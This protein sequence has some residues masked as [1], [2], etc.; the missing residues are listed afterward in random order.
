MAQV[1][2]WDKLI[3]WIGRREAEVDDLSVGDTARMLERAKQ[4]KTEV[5]ALIDALEAHQRKQVGAGAKLIA[6]TSEGEQVRV[7]TSAAKPDWVYESDDDV[8]ALVVARSLD[9]RR[10]DEET[11]EALES[12]AAAVARGISTVWKLAADKAR[13]GGDGKPGLAS[14]GIPIEKIRWRRPHETDGAKV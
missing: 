10:I 2:Q 3:A 11:G 13:I 1:S 9:T 7:S 5:V 12:E 4:L 6:E 8:L 14:L